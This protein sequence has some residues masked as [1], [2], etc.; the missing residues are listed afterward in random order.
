M[1]V[2][3]TLSISLQVRVTRAMSTRENCVFP[4]NF[5]YFFIVN[6]LY[7]GQLFSGFKAESTVIVN[8]QRQLIN[9]HYNLI[10]FQKDSQVQRK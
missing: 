5:K 1:A 10:Y 4:I 6:K 9:A 3:K 2:I 7:E 8:I